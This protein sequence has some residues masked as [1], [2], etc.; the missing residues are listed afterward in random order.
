MPLLL[1]ILAKDLKAD[2]DMVAKLGRAGAFK[3]S[4]D[5]YNEKGERWSKS[6]H[7]YLTKGDV[8]GV[9]TITALQIQP[10]PTVIEW[11]PQTSPYVQVSKLISPGAAAPGSNIGP[12]GLGAHPGAKGKV[13]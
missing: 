3:K 11:P 7:K 5:A 6:I 13:K 8:V 4:M 10:G 9:H 2:L 12:F 1:P